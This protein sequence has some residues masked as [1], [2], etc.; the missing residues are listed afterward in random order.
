MQGSAQR[1]KQVN[2]ITKYQLN[3]G[4]SSALGVCPPWRVFLSSF[5]STGSS[6]LIAA[7][8]RWPPSLLGY[9]CVPRSVPQS[10][11][12]GVRA[13]A[14]HLEKC[15]RG[16]KEAVRLFC[17]TR[18][19]WKRGSLAARCTGGYFYPVS[20]SWWHLSGR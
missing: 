4:E 11:G 6:L 10:V 14:S 3:Q 8:L 15:F 19:G 16:G 2:F 9:S 18:D 5:V 20:L 7:M 12:A 13:D 1:T 17:S